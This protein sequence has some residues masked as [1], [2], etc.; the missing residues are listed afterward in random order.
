MPG[1]RPA[2]AGRARSRSETRADSA[3]R[4]TG[5]PSPQSELQE[6]ESAGESDPGSEA[7]V[8]PQRASKLHLICPGCNKQFA[9]RTTLRQH[10]SAWKTADP[11]CRNAAHKRP[12]TVRRDVDSARDAD[13]RI[14]QMMGDGSDS[15]LAA[16]DVQ[17]P[18]LQPRHEVGPGDRDGPT[19]SHRFTQCL[20]IVYIRF[21]IFNSG[22]R[23]VYLLF[24][25]I[26][27]K[28]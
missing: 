9:D 5:R 25:S 2:L 16:R 15:G 4:I 10:W 28:V 26:L 21:E 14:R 1:D 22:L 27:Y 23:L 13:D 11:A 20:L 18:F 8:R 24:S 7:D 19:R 17:S 3:T 6:L 12:R